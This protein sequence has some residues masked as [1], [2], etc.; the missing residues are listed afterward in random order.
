M[1]K[2]LSFLAV[3]IIITVIVLLKQHDIISASLVMLV[4]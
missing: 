4:I 3:L 2:V 1:K